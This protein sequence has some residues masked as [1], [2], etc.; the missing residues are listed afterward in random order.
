MKGKRGFTLVEL[1]V[2]VLI[3]GILAAVAIPIMRG[4]I[5]SA[6]WS[7]GKAMMGTI[8]SAIRAH[9]AEANTNYTNADKSILDWTTLGLNPA[10]FTGTY[11]DASLFDWDVTYDMQTN[12]LSF[13]ITATAPATINS[14]TT[15][16][17]NH[18]G[19]WTP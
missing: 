17:L 3:V 16:T 12:D 10:D 9:C 4:K 19:V 11:F 15:V 8:A 2:V 14:P 13:T 1:M 6:K 5:D 7:E 18:Q